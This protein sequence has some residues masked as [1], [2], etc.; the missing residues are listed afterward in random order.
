MWVRSVLKQAIPRKWSSNTT[1]NW[2]VKAKRRNGL[3]SSHRSTPRMWS[4]CKS[5]PAHERCELSLTAERERLICRPFHLSTVVAET[6]EDF[7]APSLQID[8]QSC[9]RKLTHSRPVNVI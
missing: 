7:C 3:A 5:L 4:L 6:D 8:S 1:G 9:A 2:S